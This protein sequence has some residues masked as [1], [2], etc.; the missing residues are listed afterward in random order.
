MQYVQICNIQYAGEKKRET[1]D[2]RRG[3]EDMRT[4][5]HED[6][7]IRGYEDTRIRGYETIKNDENGMEWNGM[8][9]K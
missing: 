8:E 6:T 2:A 5:G 9:R 1:C 4:R 7:R 3:D